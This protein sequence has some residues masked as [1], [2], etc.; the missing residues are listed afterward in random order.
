MHVSVVICGYTMDRREV[1]T[2]AIDSVLAQTHRPLEVVIV[3]DGNPTLHERI[4]TRYGDDPAVRIDL[5]AENRGISYSRTRGAELATGEVVAFIDDDAVAE[6]AWI[7]EHVQVYAQTD[8]VAVA[9]PVLPV[10]LE[11]EP[12]WFP[13][14]FSWLVGCTEPGF[15]AD[16]E[17]IRNG[18]GSNVS[19][20]RDV[21]LDVGGYDVQT[22]RKGDRHIQAHE[23]P[24][25]IRIRETYGK[26]VVYVEDAI[27]H[28]TLFAYRGEFRWLVFRSFWQ[29]YSK[30]VMELLYP[31]AQRNES[32]FLKHLFGRAL[33][34][35]AKRT[36][37]EWS[38]VPAKEATAIVVFT[39]AVGLGYLYGLVKRSV[40]REVVEEETEGSDAD[41]DLGKSTND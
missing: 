34:S 17:E 6:Q 10:W 33:P 39:G 24:V 1:F 8:A 22:G 27:V 3:I 5:N 23:A 28:H 11:T 32:A 15:A 18:Y 7:A 37:V 4:V 26:G 36:V 25:G 30:R 21:F 9:G 2:A 14:E 12:D 20:L 16:G 35:R 41:T 13:A 31:R 19:Y 38:T 29:G 40:L